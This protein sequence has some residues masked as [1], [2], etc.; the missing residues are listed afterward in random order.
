MNLFNEDMLEESVIELLLTMGYNYAFGPDLSP[1]GDYQER[2]DHKEVIF[3]ARVKEA[4]DRIN[5]DLPGEAIEEAYR[6]IITF[7]SPMLEENNRYFHQ[8][9]VEGIEVSFND[10]QYIRT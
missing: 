9:M 2:K 6:Q 1:G 3:P 7:N 8:L 4:L 10:G 5:K